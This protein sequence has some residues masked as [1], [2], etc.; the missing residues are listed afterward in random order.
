[1][2]APA[3][4]PTPP[5]DDLPPPVVT[6]LGHRYPDGVPAISNVLMVGWAQARPAGRAWVQAEARLALDVA[7]QRV[8]DLR[9][10]IGRLTFAR[11]IDAYI[12]GRGVSGIGKRRATGAVIDAA[13]AV[14]L[15]AD[16]L[17][18]PAFWE[19]PDRLTWHAT[20]EQSCE[21]GATVAGTLQRA[22]LT[23]DP[24]TGDPSQLDLDRPRE[25]DAPPVPWQV[26]YA[27]WFADGAVVVPGRMEVQWLDADESWLRMR[28]ERAETDTDLAGELNVARRALAAAGG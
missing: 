23:F 10:G 28:I 2:S 27:D 21:A 11:I 13:A 19:R 6:W 22:R 4:W 26:R 25:A 17:L 24:D 15:F 7:G 5:Y 20:G 9:G 1:M 12:D 14:A 18:Y 8:L 16:T 3:A